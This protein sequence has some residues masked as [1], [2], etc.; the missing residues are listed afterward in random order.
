MCGICG[1]YSNESINKFDVLKRM[2]DSLV[3][4]GPDDYGFIM[5]NPGENM[6]PETVDL[7][8]PQN[9]PV[10]TFFG[11]RRLSI[12]DL[13][14][15]QQPLSN[16]NGSV[17]TIFNGEIYNYAELR[18]N[19]IQRGH[20]LKTEGDTE[21][22][23][24]LWEEY[25]EKMLEYLV[26][27]F[28]FAIYDTN[29]D[30]LFIARDRYGQKPLYY[31]KNTKEFYFASEIQA[32]KSAGILNKSDIDNSAVAQYFRYGY[33]PGPRTIY[34][35]LRSLEAGHYILLQNG[36]MSKEQYWKPNVSGQKTSI[37]L[38]ELQ[39]L[40]DESVRLRLRSDV[41][42]GVF[43]SGGIDSSLIG[44]SATRQLPKESLK[45]FTIST[46][47][48]WCDESETARSIANYLGTEHSTF[49]VKPDLVDIS[50]KLAIHYGQPFS[51]FSS[52]PTYYI[53]RET[54]KN[55]K[56]ALSGDGGD[57]LFAGYGSYI[58]KTKY[59][60]LGRIP[61]F[62][63]KSLA[64]TS[65]KIFATPNSGRNIFDALMSASLPGQKGE[66]I[67]GLFYSHWQKQCFAND[68]RET[69]EKQGTTEINK[70]YR[71]YSEAKSNN[72]VDK[73][74]EADQRMYLAYDILTKVDIASMA[75][76]LECRAPF[77]D[78][79]FAE[80]ANNIS[81]KEK[82][83]G[84]KTKYLLRKLAAEQLPKKIV[85]LPKKGFTLPMNQWIK[86]D[87]KDWMHSLIFD[88]PSNWT[89]YLQENKIKTMWKEHQSGKLNH[90]M[91]LWMVAIFN[92]WN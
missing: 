18:E 37:D 32:F 24:H 47:D 20:I 14:A 56:V 71:Y 77:L 30:A 54:A 78:H 1:I 12:I 33:I 68:F 21:V 15:S 31:S 44:A 38:V 87:L 84:G 8:S 35:N 86:S 49:S 26:G 51:D 55:V 4:R 67:S 50:K 92:L 58:N 83:K 57:E 45:T 64:V 69:L 65:E 72:P 29:S 7:R 48:H 74:L 19:L 63:R 42:L 61:D 59:S 41:P 9:R 88:N 52:V 34:N 13:K 10:R 46:G 23:V 91:R 16:E 62:M 39:T 70:Y 79:H 27:M 85:N 82:L 73:M 40:F 28:A 60:I 80:Y 5:L 90:T 17:W 43:L 11:H 3:H 6:N 81:A 25:G 36:K 76:S 66:N 22:L 75:V 53:S 89:P 2:T